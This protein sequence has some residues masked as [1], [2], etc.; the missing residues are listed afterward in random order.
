MIVR[1]HFLVN[2]NYLIPL[3]AHSMRDSIVGPGKRRYYHI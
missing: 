2:A 3:A 1:R